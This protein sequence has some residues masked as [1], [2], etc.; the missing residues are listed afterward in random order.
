[1]S[2]VTQIREVFI[3]QYCVDFRKGFNGLLAECYRLGLDPYSGQCV[4]FVHKKW[5]QLRALLG[6]SRGLILV[7]RRFEG[8]AMKAMFPF[9]EDPTFVSVSQAEL[10]LLFEGSNFTVHTKAKSW[11]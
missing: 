9:L 3:A 11:R 10:A 4:V 6:D 7:Q 1:M 5:N 8:G 2:M